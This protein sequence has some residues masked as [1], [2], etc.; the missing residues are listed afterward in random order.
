MSYENS[1]I[2][3]VQE[4]TSLPELPIQTVLGLT[5]DEQCTLPFIARYRKDRTGGLDEVQIQS[6]LDTYEEYVEI[7]NR[8]KFILESLTKQEKLTPQLEQSVA[9]AKTQ[10]QLEDIYAPFKSKR[11]TKAQTAKEKGLEP[12]A[13][14]LL[15]TPLNPERVEEKLT[16]QFV[17]DTDD[18]PENFA[19][20]LEGACDI[21]VEKFSHDPRIKE[22]LRNKFWEQGV[23]TSSLRPKAQEIKDHEKFKDF[24]DYEEPVKNLKKES[25]GHRFLAIKR[26]ESL[27]VLKLEIRIDAEIASR[28]IEKA[29]FENQTESGAY[30]LLIKCAQQAFKHYIHPSLDKEIQSELKQLADQASIQVFS[31]NIKNLLLS[32]YLGSQPVM[33]VDPG[34]RTGCKVVVIDS[35]GKYLEDCVIFPHQPRKDI[36]GSKAKIETLIERHSIGHIAIGNGTFG[37]ETLKFLEE[38]IQ[39]IV[40]KKVHAT[41]IS[42]SGAS[43]YSTSPQGRS[44]FPDMDPTV[45]GA[46]SIARRFQ[47]PLAELVKIDPKSIGVG[48]YQHDVNQVKLKKELDQVVE[49]CVNYVGV[50]ANTASAPLLAYVSGITPSAAANLVKFRESQGRI[51]NREQLLKVPRFTA[52][53]FEQAA[54]FLRIYNGTQAL[55]STFI[56]PEQYGSLIDWTQQRNM[57]LKDLIGQPQ[58]A[59]QLLQDKEFGDSIGTLTLKDIVASLKAPSQDPRTTFQTMEFSKSLSTFEDVAEGQTYP[60]VVTNLTRFGAFVDI[61]IKENGLVHV[62]EFADKFV[63]NPLD[64]FKVGQEIKVRVISKDSERRRIAL[65]CKSQ[66]SVKKPNTKITSPKKGEKDRD[67]PFSVLR[68]MKLG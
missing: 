38:N 49:S 1:A 9:S 28:L 41:L 59:D 62:S 55:D 17:T 23:M 51:D 29:F 67:N 31:N 48:Q 50:D 42:E 66:T 47:D 57:S 36:Q 30:P 15:Q 5:Y 22:T 53:V 4:K 24:F 44:E 14:I 3:F 58:S 34:V 63:S 64:H 40:N 2:P 37:R 32:P 60:G 10:N 8:R 61:G 11:K 65:S 21:L 68:N 19:E 20:A 6:I 25:A 52:K 56:H 26:G 46:I 13:D 18:T 45:R 16:A 54:G 43:I 35:T 12:L 7:E 27:K 33:G 39:P